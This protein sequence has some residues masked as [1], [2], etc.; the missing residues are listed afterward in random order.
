MNKI[1]KIFILMLGVLLILNGLGNIVDD[2]RILTY[3]I[4]SILTGIGFLIIGFAKYPR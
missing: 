4:A 3:D 1:P 2:A